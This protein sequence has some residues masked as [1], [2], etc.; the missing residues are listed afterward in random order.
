MPS[1]PRQSGRNQQHHV[2][3]RGHNSTRPRRIIPSTYPAT[4]IKLQHQKKGGGTTYQT[5]SDHT[6]YPSSKR[7]KPQYEERG[8]VHN[9]TR[10]CRIIP[11]TTRQGGRNN[12]IKGE[13]GGKTV[14]DPV[15]S[16]PLLPRQAEENSSITW[17]EGCTTAPEPVGLYPLLSR[18]SERNRSTRKE[19]GGAIVPDP[20]GSYPSLKRTHRRMQMYSERE[21]GGTTVPDPV[22]SNPLLLVEAGENSSSTWAGGGTTVPDPVGSYPL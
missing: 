4:G 13:G 8:M 10:P 15:R 5:P 22:R 11:S 19:G 18:P 1:T 21:R 16:Y 14:P 2:V 20:E 12:S 3:G 7:V 17:A 6:L 9:S